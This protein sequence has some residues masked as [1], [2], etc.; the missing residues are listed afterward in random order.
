MCAIVSHV[1]YSV[2]VVCFAIASF[3]YTLCADGGGGLCVCMHVCACLQAWREGVSEGPGHPP[4][5][6]IGCEQTIKIINIFKITLFRIQSKD[7]A[8]SIH[9]N[10]AVY[11]IH[12]N[13]SV[14]VWRG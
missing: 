7:L 12:S 11:C 9:S 5:K 13:Q 8:L 10:Q 2:T 3:C 6:Y 14:Y 4:G 1:C